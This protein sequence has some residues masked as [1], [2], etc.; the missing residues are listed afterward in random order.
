MIVD[1]SHRLEPGMPSYP[2]L[3]VPQFDTFL[4]H[5]NGGK[6][7]HYAPGT[8]FQIATYEF[9]GNT[10]TYVDAPFHRHP[11]G[12]DLAEV[13]LDRLADLAGVLV[14]APGD[15]PIEERIF[16]GI[17]VRG[18][19][20]LVHTGWS[21]GWGFD[22]YFRSGPYLTAGACEHLVHSGA[23]LVGIDCANIDN[24]NDPS[25]P[26]H[27]LLLAAGIPIVE[28][29]LGTRSAQRPMLPVLRRAAGD[30]PRNVV[31]GASFCAL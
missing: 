4:A 3:P 25:R 7:A 19:A 16:S 24:M 27:T 10:G 14:S 22:G 18:K 11:D 6:H 21:R 17:A 31:S 20:V 5:G 26:A 30:P 23:A 9:A 1:L 15:G 2:G 13:P 8:S 28:H 12:A 29:L